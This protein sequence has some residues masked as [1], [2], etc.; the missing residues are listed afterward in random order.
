MGSCVYALRGAA[1]CA[2]YTLLPRRGA[3]LLPAGRRRGP[4]C[5]GHR[6]LGAIGCVSL[7]RHRPRTVFRA[8]ASRLGDRA[9]SGGARGSGSRACSP[10]RRGSS[11]RRQP[12][13][14]GRPCSGR[15]R[16]PSGR[17]REGR[18][19][20]GRRDSEARRELDARGL[21]IEAPGRAHRPARAYGCLGYAM[22]IRAIALAATD[23]PI[24]PRTR[25]KK[26]CALT[27][28]RPWPARAACSSAGAPSWFEGEACWCGS[29]PPGKN[30]GCVSK[31]VGGGES[32][33]RSLSSRSARRPPGQCRS[34]APLPQPPPPPSLAT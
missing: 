5:V 6:T 26:G 32:S 17:W 4:H 11:P 27:G 21:E 9:G 13:Q 34:F 14:P 2:C 16:R 20:E 7:P 3:A 15:T 30:F 1:A 10:P 24:P 19:E 8:E 29:S 31:R 12:Q 23:A 33:M 22:W 25:R 18:G 28:W